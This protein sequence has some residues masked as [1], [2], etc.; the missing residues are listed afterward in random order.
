MTFSALLNIL[1]IHQQ[2]SSAFRN[3]FRSYF[4]ALKRVF[5]NTEQSRAEQ[6][7]SCS[8]T[9][10]ENR[11]QGLKSPGCTCIWRI[12]AAVICENNASR[13]T[14]TVGHVPLSPSDHKQ[15]C[16]KTSTLCERGHLGRATPRAF[17]PFHK[18]ECKMH[19][20]WPPHRIYQVQHNR[21]AAPWTRSMW[22]GL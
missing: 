12:Y 11:K 21:S 10:I 1:T 7:F 14:H 18:P 4:T 2:T 20:V 17:L 19:L 9:S 16:S 13:E 5:L 22:P 8:F 15:S 6:N 3:R